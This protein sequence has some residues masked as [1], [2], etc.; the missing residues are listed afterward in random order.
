MPNDKVLGTDPATLGLN[1]APA[2]LLTLGKL[3]EDLQQHMAHVGPA[4]PVHTLNLRSLGD[5]DL[6]Q[7]NFHELLER[8]ATGDCKVSIAPIYN[9]NTD[10]VIGLLLGYHG[11]VVR[12]D[13]ARYEPPCLR[14]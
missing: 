11:P 6:Q 13:G 3:I 4:C 9:G 10:G 12:P 5:A 1:A 7:A 2:C 14:L 8:L